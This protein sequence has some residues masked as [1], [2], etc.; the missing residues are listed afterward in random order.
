MKKHM[1]IHTTDDLNE[2][3]YVIFNKIID[4]KI[5]ENTY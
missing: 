4:E 1:E 2:D 3:A 5:Y